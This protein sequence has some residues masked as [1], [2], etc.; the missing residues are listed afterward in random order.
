MCSTMNRCQVQVFYTILDASRR[1]EFKEKLLESAAWR[2]H[3][4]YSKAPTQ[5]GLPDTA[6]II[7]RTSCCDI[8]FKSLFVRYRP[9]SQ[10]SKKGHS[11]WMF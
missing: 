3:Y 8:I 2:P 7:S 4:E 9:W 1:F 6:H 5:Y 11:K 10:T